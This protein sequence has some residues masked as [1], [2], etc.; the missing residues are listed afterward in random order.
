MNA[1]IIFIKN[2][3][4][5]KVKTRLA[6]TMGHEAAFEIYQQLLQHTRQITRTVLADK[7][8]YYTDFIA[9][10]DEWDNSIYQKHLQKQTP[11]LGLKMYESFRDMYKK[12]YEKAVIIGS[13]CIE[14]TPEIIE[15]AF[16]QL[17]EKQAVIGKATD[18]GYYAVGF[19]FSKLSVVEAIL[20]EVFLN[21]H[22]SHSQVA[23]EALNAFHAYGLSYAEL[24]ELSDIDTEEDWKRAI[25]KG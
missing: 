24:P 23:A 25:A 15:N 20:Q 2:P 21:K 13:D 7:F 8:L 4:F 3:I 19:D 6:A 14:N 10:S 9:I 1:L 17:I 18:G 22:W 16:V 5:G 12:G 11:D